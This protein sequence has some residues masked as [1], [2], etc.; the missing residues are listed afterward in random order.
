[1]FDLYKLFHFFLSFPCHSAFYFCDA[2]KNKTISFFFASKWFEYIKIKIE[3]FEPEIEFC[4][5][6]NAYVIEIKHTRFD[7]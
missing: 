5:M 2:I 6:K 1:M 4:E 3:V 7:V